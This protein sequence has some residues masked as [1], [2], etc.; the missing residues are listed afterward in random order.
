MNSMNESG[1]RLITDIVRICMERLSETMKLLNQD[2]SFPCPKQ[3]WHKTN[4]GIL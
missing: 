3:K 2:I 1:R 4:S